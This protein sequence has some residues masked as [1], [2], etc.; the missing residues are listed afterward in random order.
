M[1]EKKHNTGASGIDTLSLFFCFS[2]LST[3]IYFVIINISTYFLCF[4]CLKYLYSRTVHVVTCAALLF[5]FPLTF[6][7]T[8]KNG[9]GVQRHIFVECI[10]YCFIIIMSL[11][12]VALSFFSIMFY[13]R[14]C[15]NV[16]LRLAKV[17][18][19]A[20]TTHSIQSP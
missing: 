10:V 5:L 12:V 2:I 14:F 1:R 13:S 16:L 8:N 3:S 9:A 11:F 20:V 18:E 19:H 15:Q 6:Q 17:Y 4:Y 7:Q